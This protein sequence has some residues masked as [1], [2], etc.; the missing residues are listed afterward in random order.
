[1]ATLHLRR[2]RVVRICLIAMILIASV[3]V[4]PAAW[5][6]R[7]APSFFPSGDALAE[8]CVT[9]CKS[10]DQ[11]MKSWSNVHARQ[12]A[13]DEASSATGVP[14]NLI[15]AVM[16]LE[17]NGL[18]LGPNGAT[19]VGPMQV[20]TSNWG[21]WA[22]VNGLNLYNADDNIMA[23]ARILDRFRIQYLQW[24]QDHGIDPWLTALYAYY[25]GNPYNLRARDSPAQ[26]GA[27]ITTQEYGARIWYS[28][29]WLQDNWPAVSQAKL[30]S[31][32][33]L[34]AN[35]G[36]NPAR[37]TD[38]DLN[39]T[40]AVIG[41]D[42][43]PPGAYL[44]IDL[45]EPTR[46]FEIAWV[47]RTTGYADRLRIRVS[48]DGVTYE[49]IHVT[50]NAPAR[51]WQYLLMDRPARYVRFNVDNPNGDNAI[52]YIAEVA[53]RGVKASQYVAPPLPPVELSLPGSGGSAGATYTGRIRDGRM[54]TDWRTNGDLRPA[55]GFVYIDLGSEQPISE[56]AWVFSQTGGA[57]TLEIQI[58][59]DKATWTTIGS[60]GNAPAGNWQRLNTTVTARYVRWL[61]TNT[62]NVP[63]LGYIAEV[64]I[65]KPVETN[66]PIDET[67]PQEPA[68]PLHALAGSGGSAGAT[69]TGR[70]RDERM[71]TDWRTSGAPYPVSGYVYIDLGTEQ[72]IGSI[73]WIFSQSGGA[74]YL[75]IQVSNDKR[76]WT[77][78]G[79]AGD[80]PAGQWQHLPT[81][82]TAR[83][84][85]WA[86]TNTTGV[87]QIGYIAEVRVT[88][89]IPADEP[90]PTPTEEPEPE[91]TPDAP[92]AVDA[93]HLPQSPALIVVSL[94]DSGGS[95]P[96]AANDGALETS[97]QVAGSTGWLQADLG[98]A[99]RLTHIGWVASDAACA[100]GLTV[101]HSEDGIAW[102]T[103]IGYPAAT[104]WAWELA[105]VDS[106]ARFVRWSFTGTAPQAG[107]LAE[108]AIWG[109]AID[110]AEELAEVEVELPTEPTS[111]P[112]EIPVEPT[113]EP[114]ATDQEP[115]ATEQLQA[116][117]AIETPTEVV[118]AVAPTPTEVIE[119]VTPAPTDVPIV[120][121]TPEPE[122]E[123]PAG[124]D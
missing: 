110:E 91:P 55:S 17:S 31:D 48:E 19:A 38:G 82:V 59:N 114:S 21:W 37:A 96:A 70:V 76:A 16:K 71:D 39:T 111:T 3:P 117:P 90:T 35:A 74:P 98:I 93:S 5:M 123:T 104:A 63:Q 81:A 15:K 107:C 124:E 77:T 13:I 33:G 44:Q 4:I 56:V 115:T 85:R 22:Q 83:Y 69:F 100:G 58:S 119:V 122:P 88:G 92:P 87:E 61:I 47:F 14:E 113:P 118:E 52:G 95:D 106:A 26:G 54:D 121:P 34:H 89:Q 103:S 6:E 68:A 2:T 102:T 66:A 11:L 80:A 94:S 12:S 27:G 49:T 18:N 67:A 99:Y 78:V 84:V 10:Y 20:T 23:G 30:Q 109:S 86:I 116:E 97:W 73:E 7:H 108:I 53:V 62:S 9:T 101:E 65:R 105:T 8:E 120:E 79:T 24:A 25:A 57:P 40:W 51:V 41:K 72:E 42:G 29:Q 45:G 1:M 112:T 46:V 28:Y 60:A 64:A 43:P 36:A 32:L 75:E 50:G